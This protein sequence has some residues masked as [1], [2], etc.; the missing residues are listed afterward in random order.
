MTNHESPITLSLVIIAKNEET[1]LPDCLESVKWADEI[2]LIDSGSIDKT[3]EI[4]KKYGA[5]VVECT[6]GSFSDWRNEG[7]KAAKGK[8]IFYIDADE[9]STPELKEEIEKII[10]K[11]PEVNSETAYAVARRNFILGREFKHGGQWPD[12]QMRF[13]LKSK[14]KGYKNDLHELAQFEGKEGKL[15]NPIIHHK[16]DN[17]SDM[18]I[19]TNKW[20]EIEAKELFNSGHPRMVWWRFLR[21]MMTEL[22]FRLIKQGGVL[23]GGEGIMYSIYQS[24]SKFVTYGKLWEMQIKK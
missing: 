13:F 9:R 22:W 15:K 3:V 21:I 4:A 18:V 17:L 6:I 1:M 24:W 16:H 8:W 7:L 14:L 11:K 2:V 23:D 10:S 20:S 5:K 12:Y 19:K